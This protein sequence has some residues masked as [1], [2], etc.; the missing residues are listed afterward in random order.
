MKCYKAYTLIHLQVF[1]SKKRNLLNLSVEISKSPPEWQLRIE[2]DMISTA[3][4]ILP[5]LTSLLL[6]LAINLTVVLPQSYPNEVPAISIDCA[7]GKYPD[8]GKLKADL[9]EEV[10]ISLIWLLP[11]FYYRQR[12][13]LV[14][15]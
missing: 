13:A 4:T 3:K 11:F 5:V 10:T 2:S 6:Y 14:W 1:F 7:R 9:S 12:N 15:P 8:M